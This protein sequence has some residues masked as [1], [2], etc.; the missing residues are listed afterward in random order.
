MGE[1]GEACFSFSNNSASLCA[2]RNSWNESGYINKER[3]RPTPNEGSSFKAN[4]NKEPAA[5]TCKFGFFS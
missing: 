5:I 1:L 2:N 3:I 4:S